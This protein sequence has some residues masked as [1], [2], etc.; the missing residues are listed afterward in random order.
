MI[1]TTRSIDD[2]QQVKKTTPRDNMNSVSI[3]HAAVGVETGG[4]TA[5]SN[6]SRSDPSLREDLMA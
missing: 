3:V 4:D 1:T 5:R 6:V 2:A